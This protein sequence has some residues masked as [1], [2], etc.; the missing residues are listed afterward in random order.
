M[1]RTLLADLHIHSCL[2][3]CAGLGM[4]PK[5]IVLRS[6]EA[7]LSIIAVTDHNSAE[8]VPAV[9]AAAS[10]TGLL[11]VPGMEIST[12]EEVH[13]LGLFESCASAM[14]MQQLVFDHLMPGTNDENL[15]GLQVIANEND[16]V[17]GFNTRLLIGSTTLDVSRTVESIHR[18]N[19]IAVFSHIDRE[20]YSILSQL[21]FIPAGIGIN[22]IEI[23]KKT[24]MEEARRRFGDCADYPMIRSSD[25]HEVEDIGTAATA[26]VLERP[27][28]AEIGMALA[29]SQGRCISH[30]HP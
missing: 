26:F 13:I 7:G 24:S 1:L 23:S 15:F 30:Y 27:S 19:G 3:P 25:A 21:G 28:F 22:G 8:N 20:S 17:E 4:T 12:V 11:V 6:L 10:G 2:S 5:K 14:E 18:L 16:E 29:G 9:I